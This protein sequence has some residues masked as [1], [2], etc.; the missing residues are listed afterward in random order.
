M[1]HLLLAVVTLDANSRIL[2]GRAIAEHRTTVPVEIATRIGRTEAVAQRLSADGASVEYV[3]ESVGYLRVAI[4]PQRLERI[5]DY[6]GDVDAIGVF[7][8]NQF[9]SEL[10]GV[11]RTGAASPAKPA[12]TAPPFDVNLAGPQYTGAPAMGADRFVRKHPTFDGRGV[13]IAFMEPVDP[14]GPGLQ[15][16]YDLAGHAIRKVVDFGVVDS[17]YFPEDDGGPFNEYHGWVDMRRVVQSVD[18]RVV[19]AGKAYAVPYD[20]AFNIGVFHGGWY[21][22]EKFASAVPRHSP[23]ITVLWDRASGHMWFDTRYARTFAGAPVQDYAVNGD[24]VPLPIVYPNA[25]EGSRWNPIDV[26][27]WL[28]FVVKAKPGLAFIKLINVGNGHARM[29]A[30]SAAGNGM[31]GGRMNGIAPGARVLC[32]DDTLPLTLESILWAVHHGADILSSQFDMHFAGSGAHDVWKIVIDRIALR[33]RTVFAW[34]AGNDGPAIESLES[35][36]DAPDTFAI[37]GYLTRETERLDDG[38]DFEGQAIYSSRGPNVDGSMKPDV[39]APTQWLADGDAYEAASLLAGKWRLPR[40]YDVGGGTSQATPTAAGAIALLISAARQRGIDYDVASLRRALFSTG[41]SVEGLPIDQG[42]GLIDIP[43]AWN[44][45]RSGA[46]SLYV[47]VD[48]PPLFDKNV[49]AGVAQTYTFRVEANR[50]VRVRATWIGSAGVRVERPALELTAGVWTAVTVRLPSLRDNALRSGMVQLRDAQR[51]V[52][53]AAQPVTQVSPLQFGESNA[54]A[55][56]ADGTLGHPGYLRCFVNVPA[57]ASV[58]SVRLRESA[59]GPGWKPAVRT[60]ILKYNP[61]QFIRPDTFWSTAMWPHPPASN[62]GDWVTAIPKPEAGVWQIVLYGGDK[63]FGGLAGAGRV[64]NSPVALRAA[65]YGIAMQRC[66]QTSSGTRCRFVNRFAPFHIARA[67]LPA[68]RRSN[69]AVALNPLQPFSDIEIPV[70]RGTS[71]LRVSF[72]GAQVEQVSADLYHCLSAASRLPY[73]QGPWY[74]GTCYFRAHADGGGPLDSSQPTGSGATID[75]SADTEPGRWVVI[76]YASR[77]IRTALHFSAL[78]EQ[79][80]LRAGEAITTAS[81]QSVGLGET[82]DAIAASNVPLQFPTIES[83]DAVVT[84]QPFVWRDYQMKYLPF[85]TASIPF[86]W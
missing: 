85:V 48:R 31:F 69:V 18:K 3:D 9:D 64:P 25:H 43:G 65:V 47:V 39:L 81:V 16:A 14:Q 41:R 29:V 4:A 52:L 63:F 70:Q 49:A 27:M 54:Y 67:T 12:P 75:V 57:G 82:F 46:D 78:I 13:T 72:A 10:H 83:P 76:A 74:R 7:S 17:P 58:L 5:S 23:D 73:P 68:V 42:F 28:R 21:W 53:L 6:G 84:Y 59:G 51:G 45:L 62:D 55:V 61:L 86:S 8:S 44:V 66:T 1:I 38:I 36:E 32:I 19:F 11:Q 20:G 80:N 60:S 40:G 30:S 15:R 22:M 37:G 26:H 33:Y 50:N 71:D 2:V 56:A 34:A 35:A 24:V 79:A 77:P